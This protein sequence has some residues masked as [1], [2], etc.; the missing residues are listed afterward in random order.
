MKKGD[1]N[2]ISIIPAVGWKAMHAKELPNEDG[3]PFFLTD[4]VCWALIE[5]RLEDGTLYR[6]VKG[7][8]SGDIPAWVEDASISGNFIAY[9]G[10]NDKTDDFIESCLIYLKKEEAK[11]ALAMGKS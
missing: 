5:E 1:T 2:I 3:K 4:L 10:P 9:I 6:Y 11:H 7:F 8:S